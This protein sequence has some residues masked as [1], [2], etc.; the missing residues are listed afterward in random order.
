MVI[1]RYISC[2]IAGLEIFLAFITSSFNYWYSFTKNCSLLISHCLPKFVCCMEN[3]KSIVVKYLNEHWDDHGS[4]SMFQ[5]SELK[6]PT[7]RMVNIRDGL[8]FIHFQSNLSALQ[9]LSIAVASVHSQSPSLRPENIQEW[10]SSF[11]NWG[12]CCSLTFT[13]LELCVILKLNFIHE[14]RCS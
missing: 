5:G 11:Q 3:D 4:T 12:L 7:L 1:D 13:V 10:T 2:D 8:Y 9:S 6:A 14:Y